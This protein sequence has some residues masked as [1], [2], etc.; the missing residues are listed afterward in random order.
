MIRYLRQKIIVGRPNNEQCKQGWHELLRSLG[1][2]RVK[3]PRGMHAEKY[4][5]LGSH[6]TMVTV[7]YHYGTNHT[8]LK[9]TTPSLTW[10]GF[11]YSPHYL[12]ST[13]LAKNAC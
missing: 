12:V 2:Q 5:S 4:G 3:V 7:T 8:F 1:G 6:T 11:N 10:K 9:K 13:V